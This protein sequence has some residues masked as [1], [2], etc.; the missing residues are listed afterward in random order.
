V[1]LA[2]LDELAEHPSCCGGTP[3]A[4]SI[5]LNTIEILLDATEIEPAIPYRAVRAMFVELLALAPMQDVE[6]MF[7]SASRELECAER[8]AADL[9]AEE[10]AHRADEIEARKTSILEDL[11]DRPELLEQWLQDGERR[12]WRRA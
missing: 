7:A 12:R 1:F 6:H 2:T 8:C 9:A 4:P 5:D 10:A 3:G 11:A